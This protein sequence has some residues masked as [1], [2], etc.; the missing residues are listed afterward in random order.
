MKARR[1][2]GFFVIIIILCIV[3]RLSSQESRGWKVS[4]DSIPNTFQISPTR[5]SYF[6]LIRVSYNPVIDKYVVFFLELTNTRGFIYSR[7]YDS[8][9]KKAGKFQ[10]IFNEHVSSLYFAEV[11]YNEDYDQFLLV[12]TDGDADK[13]SCKLLDGE[14]KNLAPAGNRDLAEEVVIIKQKSNT[15]SAWTPRAVWVSDFSRYVVAW[16]ANLLGSSEYH[17]VNGFYMATLKPNLKKVLKPKQVRHQTTL[18]TFYRVTAFEPLEDKLLWGSADDGGTWAGFWSRP[19]VFF[20][21]YDGEILDGP[22]YAGKR[23]EGRG[24]VNAA[25]N[26]SADLFLLAWNEAD[27][28]SYTRQTYRRSN[29]RMMRGDGTFFKG[30]RQVSTPKTQFQSSVSAKYNSIEDKYFLIWPEYKIVYQANPLLAFSGDTHKRYYGG[31]IWY[32]WIN[33]KGKPKG[34]AKPLTGV[35]TDPYEALYLSDFAH[36]PVDNS[37]FVCYELENVIKYTTSIWGLIYK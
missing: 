27:D 23:V 31:K 15:W 4:Q 34:S 17:P 25:Y 7:L 12:W 37:Y 14:G 33:N 1:K 22:I 30:I 16:T 3:M 6:D 11:A 13:I 35:F 18:N 29:Y 19:M 26:P 20:T 21:D 2:I 8:E 28:S 24:S 9:G 36:N 32:R 10:E 5:S